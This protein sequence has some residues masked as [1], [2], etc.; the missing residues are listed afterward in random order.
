MPFFAYLAIGLVFTAASYYLA[1]KNRPSPPK[2][3]TLEDFNIQNPDEGAGVPKIYGSVWVSPKVAWFGH[4]Y[5]EAIK[6]DGGK[7]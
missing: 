2:P 7:K 4:L 6:Q 1:R 5:T 3:G